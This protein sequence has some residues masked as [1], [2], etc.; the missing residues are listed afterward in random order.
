M[1][2]I[3]NVLPESVLMNYK[4]S[5]HPCDRAIDL[6]EKWLD[7]EIPE[8][9]GVK[10]VLSYEGDAD[11]ICMDFEEAIDYI[12]SESF[13][14]CG[15]CTAEALTSPEEAEINGITQD[16][17]CPQCGTKIDWSEEDD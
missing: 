5:I 1:N 16:N 11:I 6:F 2:K 15:H 10:P 4:L 7:T 3:R 8:H 12:E 17:Y 13:N 14:L 9:K